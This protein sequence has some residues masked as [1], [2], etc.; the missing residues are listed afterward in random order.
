MSYFLLCP[1]HHK[2]SLFSDKRMYSGLLVI[3]FSK[4]ALVPYA[5]FTL[6][7]RVSGGGGGVVTLNG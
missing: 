2:T 7:L 4:A 1:D 5:K 3:R 6:S